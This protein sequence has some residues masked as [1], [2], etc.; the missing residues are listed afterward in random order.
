MKPWAL[1][2]FAA[3]MTSA[4]VASGFPKRMFSR[5]DDPNKTGSCR[6]TEQKTLWK[7]DRYDYLEVKGKVNQYLID[8]SDDLPP[9][10]RQIEYSNIKS[11]QH[12]D[13]TGWVVETLQ[14]GG[15][16]GLSLHA[17]YESLLDSP[18]H[19]SNVA[20]LHSKSKITSSRFS[21][22]GNSFT[23]RQCQVEPLQDLMTRSCW[24][25]VR[26]KET[27]Q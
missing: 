22:D 16:S 26:E 11:I 6:D 23:R 24:I 8:K 3:L 25:A 10:P 21:N 9:Q 19:Y 18:S 7:L 2:C 5:M 17:F 4:S 13:S 14:Q 20:H 27:N 12:D 1:A 15:H